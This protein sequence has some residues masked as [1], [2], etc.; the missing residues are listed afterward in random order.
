MSWKLSES[1]PKLRGGV[2]A[3]ATPFGLL[4]VRLKADAAEYTIDGGPLLDD[5]CGL[6]DLNEPV[7][8]TE[9]VDSGRRSAPPVGC[10]TSGPTACLGRA[11]IVALDVGIRSERA[12]LNTAPPPAATAGPAEPGPR[13]FGAEV[14]RKLVAAVASVEEPTSPG[15]AEG[16]VDFPDLVDRADLDVAAHSDFKG[17]QCSFRRGLSHQQAKFWPKAHV[18]TY[19]SRSDPRH[20]CTSVFGMGWTGTVTRTF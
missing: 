11:R 17:L 20:T 4:A 3:V 8:L 7:D 13:L 10:G 15:L 12:L 5:L 14:G 18:L 19:T 6:A 2:C 9:R 16:V 1:V